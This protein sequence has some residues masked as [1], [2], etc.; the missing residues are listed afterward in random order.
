MNDGIQS[1]FHSLHETDT[2]ISGPEGKLG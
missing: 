1:I 2:L